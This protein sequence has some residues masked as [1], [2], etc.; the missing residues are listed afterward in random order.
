[1]SPCHTKSCIIDM[2][3]VGEKLL[4]HHPQRDLYKSLVEKK[5]EANSSESREN[6]KRKSF[7]MTTINSLPHKYYFH[8]TKESNR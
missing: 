7:Q 6:K 4:L 2:E 1:M 3:I 8:S 5:V